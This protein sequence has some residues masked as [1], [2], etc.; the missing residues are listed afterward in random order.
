MDRVGR[1]AGA[2]LLTRS[3]KEDVI[4]VDQALA[5]P[6]RTHDEQVRSRRRPS[7]LWVQ[8]GWGH[9]L[10]HVSVGVADQSKVRGSR[11]GTA[12]ACVGV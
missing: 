1:P 7:R 10:K 12:A 9:N 8:V 2:K 4:D 5:L 6:D 3:G 11:R